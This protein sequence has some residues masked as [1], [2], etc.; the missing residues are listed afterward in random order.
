MFFAN[1]EMEDSKEE[2]PVMFCAHA[3]KAESKE[4]CPV[5]YSGLMSIENQDQVMDHQAEN[6]PSAQVK[7]PNKDDDRRLF[8]VK[9]TI[10][11]WNPKDQ[12]NVKVTMEDLP[13][14][15]EIWKPV[16]LEWP[17]HFYQVEGGICL[18]YFEKDRSTA[19][20]CSVISVQEVERKFLFRV[21]G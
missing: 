2:P 19:C 7:N 16:P 8:Q 11:D 1:D 20:I 3:E 6:E 5:N 15:L 18:I 9:P 12:N 17:D 21:F 14:L 10:G 13:Q 4:E